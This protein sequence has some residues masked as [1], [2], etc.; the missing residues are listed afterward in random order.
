M[1]IHKSGS[2]GCFSSLVVGGWGTHQYVF[3]ARPLAAL[4]TRKQFERLQTCLQPMLL[5]FGFL[6]Y[7]RIK[8][9]FF[10]FVFVCLFSS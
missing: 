8:S 7:S 3:P 4:L 2:S 5:P 1:E 10:G 9:K 6:S